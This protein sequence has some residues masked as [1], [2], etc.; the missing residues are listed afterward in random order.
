MEFSRK[1]HGSGKKGATGCA[2]GLVDCVS[3]VEA[4]TRLE[5]RGT[6]W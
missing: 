1:A 6:L 4:V 5:R 3:V 2:M